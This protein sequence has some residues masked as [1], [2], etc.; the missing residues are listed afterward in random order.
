MVDRHPAVLLILAKRLI[1]YLSPLVLHIDLALFWE[2]VNAGQIISSQGENADSIYIVLHGRLRA[3]RDQNQST[4]DF[5][6]TAP[7]FNFAG[8]P[9]NKELYDNAF[10]SSVNV[11]STHHKTAPSTAKD[12]ESFEI[13]GEYGQNESVGESEV[14]M[15]SQRPGMLYAIRDTEMIIMPKALFEA[16]AQQNPK[17]TLQIARLIASRAGSRKILSPKPASLVYPGAKSAPL[18]NGYNGIIDSAASNVNLKTVALLPIN[19]QVP[20]LEFAERLRD[21]FHVLGESVNLLNTAIVMSALGRHAFTRLGKLKLMNWLAEQE[22]IFRLV[23]YVADGGLN[24]P[25]TQRCIRQVI[26]PSLIIG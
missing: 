21:S 22:E 23:L 5:I 26:N 18:N 8:S 3:I 6:K 24:S 4:E 14:L 16:L 20:V 12:T 19:G 13:L 1:S 11:F 9:L 2:H 25:W 17:I 15:D 10:S 7:S